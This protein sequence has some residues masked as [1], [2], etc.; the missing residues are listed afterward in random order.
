MIQDKQYKNA[1]LNWKR[2]GFPEEEIIG[3]TSIVTKKSSTDSPNKYIAKNSE[4]HYGFN[5]TLGQPK[6]I[7]FF[8]AGIDLLSYWSLNKNMDDCRLVCLEG[9]K[10]KTVMKMIQEIYQKYE[11]L[12]RE[13][14]FQLNL[15]GQSWGAI[16]KMK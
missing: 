4:K 13:S 12:P 8:E 1:V 3:A 9:R 5:I 2:Y 7:Y 15:S 11:F 6:K 14:R 10:D 16:G